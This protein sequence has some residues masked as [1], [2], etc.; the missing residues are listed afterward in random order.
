MT[1]GYIQSVGLP[2]PTIAFALAALV[3]ILGGVALLLGFRTRTTAG[4][5]FVF[6]FVTA[7][8]FHKHLVDQ[9]QFVHFFTN[10][11]IAGGL[12][13]VLA[14]GGGRISLDARLA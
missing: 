1:I 11:A 13:N 4:I 12:L 5:L 3:E 7:A 10:V 6:T 14:F 9:N 8:F 2:L